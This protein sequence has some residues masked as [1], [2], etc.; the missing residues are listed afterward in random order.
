MDLTGHRYGRLLVTGPA[1]KTGANARWYATCDCG[2][3][4]NV[5]GPNL[6]TGSTRSCGCLAME[7]AKAKPSLTLRHGMTDTP[8]WRVWSSMLKRCFSK[9]TQAYKDYGARGITVCDR[10]RTFENFHADM[11]DRPDGLTLDRIDMNGDYEPGNCRW[12]TVAEQNRNKR[13]TKR[14]TFNGKTLCVAE[15]ARELE[16]SVATLWRRIKRGWPMEEVLTKPVDVRYSNK[17]TTA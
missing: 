15:W 14:I 11:G 2:A 8:T 10:W 7:L 16:V 1:P 13:D 17:K 4:V 5:L 6:R 9:N 12:A 3:R